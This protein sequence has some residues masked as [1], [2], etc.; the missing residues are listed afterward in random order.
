MKSFDLFR[1][2]QDLYHELIYSNSCFYVVALDLIGQTR[3]ILP[4]AIAIFVSQIF[5]IQ[6]TY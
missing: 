6:L 5:W 4:N 3:M 1:D 2:D